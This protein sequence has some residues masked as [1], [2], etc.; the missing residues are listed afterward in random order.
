MRL[1]KNMFS[2]NI[3]SNYKDK[4][5]QSSSAIENISSGYK[6]N[7]AKDNPNKIGQSEALKIQVLSNSA[8]RRN[9]QDT[10]SMIQTFDGAMQEMN[11]T[12]ERL[13]EL[14]VQSGNGA[15]AQSD[16]EAIQEEV[17]ALTSHIDQMA[18]TT[19]FNGVK[20][21][22]E[23]GSIISSIGSMEDETTKIPQIDLTTVGLGLTKSNMNVLDPDNSG[24]AI[25]T[26]DKAITIVS[27]ARSRYGALQIRLENTGDDIDQRNI[28]LEKSQ[29]RIADADLA[30]EMLKQ[31]QSDILIQSS[32]ALMAQSNKLPQDALQILQ[33]IK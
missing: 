24:V 9:I 20:L 4:L 26:V 10:N 13:K 25:E 2:L 6:L 30:E 5:K 28:S 8:A 23:N 18:K 29:S 19:D 11:S 12:L 17:N 31:A 32:I 3:Y 1:S 15:L 22:N 14:T 16:K 7:K 27:A 21:I 33:N